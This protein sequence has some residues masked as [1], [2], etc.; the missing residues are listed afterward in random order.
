MDLKLTAKV[1]IVTGGGGGCGR[2]YCLALAE[3]GARVV[4]ADL[5]GEAAEQVAKEIKE[6]G[7][8][9][10]AIKADITKWGDVTNMV[11]IALQE[12]GQIDIL[13]N[14]A[15]IRGMAKIEEFPEELWDRDMDVNLR[16]PFFCTKAVAG[17]MK[18]RRYGKIINQ[19]SSSAIN[20]HKAGGSAYAAAK[21]GLLGFTRSMAGEL[22]PYNINVNAITPGMINTPFIAAMPPARRGEIEKQCPLG[23]IAEPEDLVGLVLFLA[24]DRSSYITAQTI[25]IDGGQRPS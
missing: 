8:E 2:A 1:A 5:N 25:M 3:E 23:R 6:Q 10:L 17:H 22:G 11:D 9:A 19:S 21:A 14:N 15:G 20:G 24:S 4:V 7:G 16:G 13:V 18:E 12:F